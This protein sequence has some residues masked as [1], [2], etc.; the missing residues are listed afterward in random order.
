MNYRETIIDIENEA[1][2]IYDLLRQIAP[3]EYEYAEYVGISSE[4]VA[5]EYND[6]CGCHPEM[7]IYY[8]PLEYLG[9]RS[10]KLAEEINRVIQAREELKRVEQEEK[11]K[12]AEELAYD[13]RKAAYEMLKKEFG[14]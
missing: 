9:M 3:K 10:D 7:R 5:M 14:E 11:K 2:R 4:G 6:S 12:K 13:S 1:M 8:I